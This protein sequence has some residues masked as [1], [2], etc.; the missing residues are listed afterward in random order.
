MKHTRFATPRVLLAALVVLMVLAALVGPRG[1]DSTRLLRDLAQQ[2]TTGWGW[3][4][5][6]R[7]RMPRVLIAATTG[8]ALSMAGVA[9][10]T[11]LR[12]PIADAGVLGISCWGALGAVL[13]LYLGLN[14]VTPWAQPLLAAASALGALSV[15]LFATRRAQAPD[16]ILMLGVGLAGIGAS[17][18][19]L[20]LSWSLPDWK[21]SRQM[22]TWLLGGLEARTW[23]HVFAVTPLA[24]C[25]I[26]LLLAE[27]RNLDALR[28][29]R[30]EATSLGV[31]VR[32]LEWR[33]MLGTGL[34]AGAAAAAAGAIGFV[35]I[36]VPYLVRGHV[37]MRHRLWLLN[38]GGLGA[39]FLVLA[40]L[41][42][43]RA[44]GSSE[45][46]LGV[47][48]GLLGAPMLMRQ[49]LQ[50]REENPC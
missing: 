45:I 27:H 47:V 44:P 6:L 46:Q 43:R 39:S 31:D 41:L 3:R 20:L 5:L 37:C 9:L 26:L 22:M 34:L 25:G 1:V 11:W 18:I 15:L 8:A 48:T 49:L 38:A 30:I 4:V 21:A 14:Q 13:A 17:M 19:S 23:V 24:L 36:I 50:K 12:N 32:R 7:L 35:G 42:A 40:D 2:G 29:G 16:R 28:L 10:Q 33:I